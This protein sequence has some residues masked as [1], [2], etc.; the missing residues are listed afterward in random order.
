MKVLTLVSLVTILAAAWLVYMEQVLGH[1]GHAE[2]SAVD[3]G[4]ILGSLLVVVWILRRRGRWL[5]LAAGLYAVAALA[6]GAWELWRLCQ[7]AEFEGFAL[8][9]SLILCVQAGLTLAGL[10]RRPAVPHS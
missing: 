6:L 2:R 3:A 9:V 4:L 5:G 10:A 7:G 1:P 8:V